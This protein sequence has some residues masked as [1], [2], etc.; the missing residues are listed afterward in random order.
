MPNHKKP[1]AIRLLE[2]D[3]GKGKYPIN[4]DEPQPPKAPVECPCWLT[5][6]ARDEWERIAPSLEAMGVLSCVD[7]N[8]FSAYCTAYSTYRQASEYLS[9]HEPVYYAANGNAHPS[10]YVNI[11]NTAMT[12][13]KAFAAEFGLTPASRSRIIAGAKLEIK[14]EEHDPMADLLDGN[15]NVIEGG[16]K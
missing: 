11:M 4:K 6:Y 7:I 1:T 2:G 14:H 8:A 15:F 13:M 9:S 12:T 10:P 3:R 5:G 16:A